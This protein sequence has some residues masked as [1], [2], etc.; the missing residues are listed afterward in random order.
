[1]LKIELITS[2]RAGPVR[3]DADFVAASAEIR[4][5]GVTAHDHPG[6]PILCFKLTIEDL[7]PTAVRRPSTRTTGSRP[8][9]TQHSE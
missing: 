2:G 3:V 9:P 5:E 7:I 6:G 1:L 8:V 4:R